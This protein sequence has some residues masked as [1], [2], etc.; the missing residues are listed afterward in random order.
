MCQTF[1]KRTSM[2]VDMTWLVNHCKAKVALLLAD[3]RYVTVQFKSFHKSVLP[4]TARDGPPD[5]D[6]DVAKLDPIHRKSFH[7]QKLNMTQ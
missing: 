4:V 3:N 1:E 6:V 2:L 7:E 5:V